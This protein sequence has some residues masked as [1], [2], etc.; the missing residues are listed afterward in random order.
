MKMFMID[1]IPAIS[2][3]SERDSMC[4]YVIIQILNVISEKKEADVVN[5]FNISE[6]DIPHSPSR[7]ITATETFKTLTTKCIKDVINK[8]I[9][10]NR[11]YVL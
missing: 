2:F 5:L 1:Q 6:Q 7:T 11:G 4:K 10:N 8:K 3:Y 9:V